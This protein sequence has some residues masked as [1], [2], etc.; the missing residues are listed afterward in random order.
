MLKPW[1]GP[2]KLLSELTQ[3]EDYRD[4]HIAHLPKIIKAIHGSGY[5]QGQGKQQEL[6]ENHYAEYLSLVL[7]RLVYDNPR[8]RV[9]SRRPASQGSA[10]KAMQHAI[11]RWVRD[12]HYYDHLQAVAQDL[13]MGFGISMVVSEPSPFFERNE[14]YDIRLPRVYRIDQSRFV[15]DPL[16]TTWADAKWYGHSV[17]VDKNTLLQEAEEHPEEYDR[18]AIEQLNGMQIEDIP[19][20]QGRESG[21]ERDELLVYEI[22]AP[23]EELKDGQGPEKGYNGVVYTV[24]KGAGES[25]DDQK[26]IRKPFEYYGP[27]SGRYVMHGAYRV[28]GSPWPLSPMQMVKAQ[29]EELDAHVKASS[30]SARKYKRI[31][32][33]GSSEIAKKIKN[34]E[35][36]LVV[37]VPT[38]TKDEVHS[39]E[40]GGLTD[41]MVQYLAIARDRLD[42]NSGIN[43]AQRGNVTGTGT[44]TENSIASDAS[45]VRL[46]YLKQRFA[47]GVIE[48]LKAIGWHMYHDE[49]VI[50]PLGEE[51]AEAMGVD[52]DAFY[53]GGVGAE[54][55]AA[56]LSY[57]DLELEIE[58]FSLER[59][60]DPLYQRNV[61]MFA[62]FVLGALPA[63]QA[64]PAAVMK[65]FNL[66]GQSLN[67][68]DAGEIIDEL[69][70]AFGQVPDAGMPGTDP[71]AAAGGGPAVPPMTRSIGAGL[72]AAMGAG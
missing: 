59:T 21:L 34:T 45:T 51:G 20:R 53:A 37:T 22:W 61:A 8:V 71:A 55:R 10:A 27:A 28:P 47:Q 15:L 2:E 67:L 36:D 66:Y 39:V 41:Q 63:A 56:G 68:P 24:I 44:A 13:L 12:T 23:G 25:G 18:A 4:K 48:E 54:E 11:N 70:A 57:N 30:R 69:S 40:I 52:G 43:D 64:A 9:R 72:G 38:F 50:M 14:E 46:S 6:L 35:H 17:I 5:C 62:Q 65:I 16:A 3:A 60:S 31:I 32:M 26:W 49:R 33:V 1:E 29:V 7:P 42:R 58:P 19:E